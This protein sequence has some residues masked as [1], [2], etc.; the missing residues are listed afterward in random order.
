MNIIEKIIKISIFSTLF[1]S[2]FLKAEINITLIDD[3]ITSYKRVLKEI[4]SSKDSS[5]NEE[6][7]LEEALLKKLIKISKNDT[8]K[9]MSSKNRYH[10]YAIKS[11]SDYRKLYENYIIDLK[12]KEYISNNLQDLKSKKEAILKQ[13]ESNKH[14]KIKPIIL[15]IQYKL[16]KKEFSI[17]NREVEELKKE[18]KRDIL[19]FEIKLKDIFLNDKIAKEH[20]L[21]YQK[22]ISS[23][24]L[25]IRTYEIRKERLGLIKDANN[26]IELGEQIKELKE[27]EK[28]TKAIEAEEHFI[29]FSK[30][31]KDRDIDIV[32][33]EKKALD[34]LY[35]SIY[36]S[37][38]VR[39]L[40]TLLLRL[41]K[42]YLGTLQTIKGS[43]KEEFKD[44]IYTIWEKINQPILTIGETKISTI[45]LSL[46]FLIFIFGFL[47]GKI[48]K[49]S[50]KRVTKTTHNITPST[51]MLLANLGYYLIVIISFFVMLNILGISLSSIA[52]VAGA[53]SVGIGFGLQNIVSNFVSGLILMFERSLKIGDFIEFNSG[54]RGHVSDIRMR[55]T[56]ITTNDNI[57]VI[58]PNQD[59]I[60]NHV[61]N[62]TMND[63]IRRFRI[64]FGVAYG[65]D[66]DKV[67]CII[68][69]AVKTSG[70]LD[71]Y[72][73]ATKKTCIIMTEMGDSS[74]NFE[75]FVWIKGREILW[76]RRTKARFL[77]LIYKTLNTH[78]IEIPFPQRDIHLKGID[79]PIPVIIKKDFP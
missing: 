67:E 7:V 73:N 64:P 10:L 37:N 13:I 8:N 75:L 6:L 77:R 78:G 9:T 49:L 17:L 32:Q 3:N 18:L 19:L 1:Y 22:V 35:D 34:I 33:K 70:G 27:A 56:T 69:E 72:E 16:Y 28:T 61:I 11:E 74:V 14:I 39:E 45:K 5:K 59:L 44:T 23:L 15:K 47:I 65:T 26:T 57:D 52:L 41:Q 68:L 76:P 48:Y 46:A 4:Q 66:A 62:W 12:N 31:L 60:Q 2:S 25:H 38:I 21:N 20:I 29:I 55:S 42:H 40:D 36:T 71:I 63:R 79:N 51:Q 24:E 43:L 58:V 30:A 53:L 50:I 54:I